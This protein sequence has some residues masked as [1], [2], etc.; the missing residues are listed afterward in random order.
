MNAI[1]R[2]P[3]LLGETIGEIGFPFGGIQSWSRQFYQKSVSE[4]NE[5]LARV[6]NNTISLIDQC[7]SLYKLLET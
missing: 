1:T 6:D 2:T 4:A 3:T 5:L 7:V